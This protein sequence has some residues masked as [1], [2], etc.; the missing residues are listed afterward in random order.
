[1]TLR[2][3]I[4]LIVSLLTLLFVAAMLALQVR[5]MR[6]SIQEEVVAAN[7]VAAQLLNRTAWLYA[8]QGTPAMLSFL[9]GVGR[10][11]SN[12]ITL[13]DAEEHVLYSSPNSV[14]KAGRDAP[15]W[16]DRLVSPPPS[17]MSIA[18]PGGKLIVSSNASRAVLDAWDDAALLTL[19]ALGLLLVVNAG[20]FWLVGR[21]TRPFADI[22]DALNQLESGRF[23]VSLRALPGTEAAA[24]GAAFNRMVG[25][26]QQHIET[27]RRAV[28]AE[29]RLSESREL[30]RWVDQKIEQE[31]RLIARELH[32]ELGQSVTAMRSMALSIA[33]RVQ[34]LD[35]QSEQAARLIAE[36]SGRLYTAM[37]GMIPRLTPLVLDK[38]GLVAALEDLVE[39]TRNS[40]GGVQVEWHL[41]IELDRLR[42]DTDTALVLYRAAQEGITNALRHG[43]AHRIVLALQ[44]DEET[45]KL[46]LTDDGRGLPGPDAARETSTGHYGLR[47]L[48]ERID[49]LGGDLRLEPAAPSG[50]QLTVRLPL[51]AAA[52][53]NT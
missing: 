29:S 1:M 50:A 12:D 38:F 5:A 25:M 11:R 18:F 52:A 15:D 45:V 30:G 23:D 39:R 8:A 37:H 3:K 44:G 40:H 24:I 41:E 14:Y 34:A 10:V 20:V 9:Q 17:Q 31:R 2:L 47:W 36:E 35:P 16:F 7:R 53:E 32:D 49:S 51:P 26:L 6:E 13:L 48:A 27:E 4:N 28:R 21:A 33:Q 19:S 43:E 46:T 22:V 42:L